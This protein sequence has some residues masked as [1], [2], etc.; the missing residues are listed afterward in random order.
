[1]NEIRLTQY[2]SSSGCGCKIAPAVLHE[3]IAKSGNW[4]VENKMLLVGNKSM[5]DATVYKLND[6]LVLISSVDFFTA[7]VDDP[8]EFGCIAA[9][10]A[11]SDIYAMGAKPI[12]ANAILG[13]PVDVLGTETAAKVLAGAKSICSAAAIEIAGGHSIAIKEP[14]FGLSVNGICETRNIKRNNTAKPGNLLYLS[15]PIGIGILATAL[16]RD[17]IASEDYHQLLKTA[18]E[19]N[20]LGGICGS[21]EWVTAMTDVTGFGLLGHLVEM[22]ADGILSVELEMN[23]IPL[24]S[25]I[26]KYIGLNIFPDNTWKNW[27]EYEKAVTGVEGA[28]MVTLCDP[29]TN[30]GLLIAIDPAYQAEFE[31]MAKENGNKVFKIGKFTESK[32]KKVD[33][34]HS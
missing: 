8:F 17:K 13:W 2:S 30:G 3:I 18:K 28:E 29:Q 19:L 20:S 22:C 1:M 24:I 4:A 9:A 25:G 16:K 5:D 12:F 26:E 34:L 7:I 23:K 6:E 10:N 14:I 31:N 27:N 15:K 21:K 33:I 11:I 32:T